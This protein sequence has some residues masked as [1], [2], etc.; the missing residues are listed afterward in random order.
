[1]SE[2]TAT[3]GLTQE[4]VLALQMS[5]LA[6]WGIGDMSHRPDYQLELMKKDLESSGYPFYLSRSDQRWI[7]ASWIVTA[8]VA[9]G[10]VIIGVL[11]S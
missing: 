4:E 10:L 8:L 7:A 5:T 2:P 11:I 9:S 3:A 6:F 1:M